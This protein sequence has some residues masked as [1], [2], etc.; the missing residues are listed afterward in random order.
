MFLSKVGHFTMDNASNNGTMMTALARIFA[1]HDIP[2]NT[3]DRRIMCF[4]HAVDLC[5][6][7]VVSAVSAVSAVSGGHDD[8]GDSSSSSDDSTAEPNLIAKARAAVRVIRG[9]GMRRDGF[10]KTVEEGNANGWFK[11]GTSPETVQLPK[12]QLLRDVRT[13]WDSVHH[14]L[15]RLRD[16]RPVWSYIPPDLIRA[17]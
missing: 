6:G 13:R 9:S 2:F 1:K 5:S 4:A 3:C 10:D 16:M 17:K 7:R 11:V 8:S 15:K 14:M 12:L